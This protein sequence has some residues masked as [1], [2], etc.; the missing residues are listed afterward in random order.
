MNEI[1]SILKALRKIVT[2]CVAQLPGQ[3]YRD[4][5]NPVVEERV[6]GTATEMG[7]TFSCIPCFITSYS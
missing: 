7:H 5:T 3:F 4:F 6:F 1:M 2:L